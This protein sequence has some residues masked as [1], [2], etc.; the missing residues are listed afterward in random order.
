MNTRG[1]VL[2]GGGVA[3]IS[4]MVGLIAGLADAGVDLSDA[5]SVVG[6]SAGSVVGALLCT[7]IAPAEMLARQTDPERQSA[8]IFATV[9]LDEMAVR[10]GAAMSDASSPERMR[11]AIGAMALATETVPESV[12]RA[13]LSSRLPV[14]SWP[15]RLRITA[16]DAVSGELAVFDRTCPHD[17]VDVVAAS[18]AVPGIW[19]PVTLGERRY[20]DGGVRTALN[21][22]LAAGAD[23]VLVLAPLGV[24]GSGPLSAGLDDARPL[25]APA[26]VHALVPDADSVAAMGIN[27]L[28]PATRAPAARAG[29]AQAAADVDAVRRLWLA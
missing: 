13:V 6:T 22:D 18:C 24:A 8:E 21:A 26:T 4:W 17:L 20:I 1:L 5:D 7:G 28:D 16:V 14:Q 29:W 11:A 2:G 23:A 15:D 12:R 10:F 25:L 3:G 19:P 9:D 27:P